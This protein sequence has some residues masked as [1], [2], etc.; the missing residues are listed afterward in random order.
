VL[1][2]T[3]RDSDLVTH[4]GRVL[5]RTKS[6]PT[7]LEEMANVLGRTD[8]LARVRSSRLVPLR[9]GD[10]GEALA[11]ELLEVLSGY[12]VPVRKLRYQTDPEQAM[13]GTDIVAFHFRQDGSIQDLH[14]VECKLRTSQSLAAAV[15]AHNQLANDRSH[16]YADTLLFLGARLAEIDSNVYEAFLAYLGER[17]RP[18]RGSYGIVLVW[19]SNAWDE[20]SLVRVEEIEDLLDPLRVRV[21]QISDLAILIESVYQSI[22]AAVIAIDD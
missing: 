12:R 7:V 5:V 13:H 10:F 22:G 18:E 1:E 19:D 21:I 20:D 2:Q 11:C 6:D 16:G 17:P 14:F 9:R 3:Q 4:L 8:A 15:D